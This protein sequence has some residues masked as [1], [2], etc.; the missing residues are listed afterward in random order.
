MMTSYT[1]YKRNIVELNKKSMVGNTVKKP[2]CVISYNNAKK[3]IDQLASYYSDLKKM[4]K[5]YKK[6]CVGAHL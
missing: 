6:N 3:G 4:I 2:D 1:E 5:W